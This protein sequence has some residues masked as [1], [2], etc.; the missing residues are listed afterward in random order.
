MNTLTTRPS[1]I[2]WLILALLFLIS[3]VTYIARVNISMTAR[4]MMPAYGMTDQQ[5]G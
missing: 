5:M 1:Q 3:I 2:R 4:Q